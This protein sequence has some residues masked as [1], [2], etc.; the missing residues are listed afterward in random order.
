[1]TIDS[2]AFVILSVVV[3][4]A[5]AVACATTIARIWWHSDVD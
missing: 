1:M 5:L 4:I 3:M 2:D